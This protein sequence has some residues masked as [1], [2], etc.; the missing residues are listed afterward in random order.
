M[1]AKRRATEKSSGPETVMS[2]VLSPT[3]RA[4][5]GKVTAPRFFVASSIALSVRPTLSGPSAVTA[6]L[7]V[8]PAPSTLSRSTR[9][10][11]LSPVSRKRGIVEVITT[12][13][14]TTTSLEPWP[15]RFSL[16]AT[17]MTRTVPVKAGI[18][19][20]TSAVPSGPTV[21]MPE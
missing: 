10:V 5:M 7:Y 3:P 1:S 12:G 15:T 21:T 13:S 9:R 18:S 11:D 20:S 14:R 19:N 4:A 17:A 8:P 6:T 16:Q 2:I